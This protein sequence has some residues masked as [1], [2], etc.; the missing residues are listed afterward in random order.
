VDS[1]RTSHSTR[2]IDSAQF[3][4]QLIEWIYDNCRLDST[5]VNRVCTNDYPYRKDPHIVSMTS[6]E[7]MGYLGPRQ[8]MSPPLD[9]DN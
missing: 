5:L 3:N 2:A 9:P 1:I 7:Y 4:Q 6:L 8:R